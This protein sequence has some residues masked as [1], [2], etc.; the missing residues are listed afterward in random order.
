MRSIKNFFSQ[1]DV[2]D[3]AKKSHG[4]N[5]LVLILLFFICTLLQGAI[6]Y[7]AIGF[8][9]EPYLQLLDLFLTAILSIICLVWG[10][11]FNKLSPYSMGLI[12][13]VA[14]VEYIIGLMIGIVMISTPAIICSALGICS[15]ELS[16]TDPR[17]LLTILL[18]FIG[19]VIQGFSEELFCRSCFFVG[20]TERHSIIFSILASASFFVI[21]HISN[22]Q[23]SIIGLINIFLF[24]IF[25]ALYFLQRGNIWGISAIHTIWNFVQGNVLGFNVSGTSEGISL[26]EPA[27]QV[28]SERIHGGAFGLE[29]GIIVTAI[30]IASIVTISLIGYSKKDV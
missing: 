20:L 4:L 19:F 28:G 11:K 12:K 6:S 16:V 10:L 30:L 9:S 24:G 27:L 15:F 18:F 8:V 3:P 14:F 26:Y 7:I 23:L 5:L 2:L 1:T 29:G 21:L 22:P 13:K 25:A 17:N